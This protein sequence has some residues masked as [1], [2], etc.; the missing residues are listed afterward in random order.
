MRHVHVE[1]HGTFLGLR[2]KRLVVKR[3]EGEEREYALNRTRSLTVHGRAHSV[4]SALLLAL[5]ARG[6]RFSVI[7]G[8]GDSAMLVESSRHATAQVRSSQHHQLQE[9]VPCQA[10]CR[11]VIATKIANQRAVLLYFSKY[12]AKRHEPDSAAIRDA[13]GRLKV[14]VESVRR[15]RL[16]TNANWRD[17]LLGLEGQ[18]ASV[19]WGTLAE[20]IMLPGDFE[21][22]EG[23]GARDVANAG[24]NYGYAILA[25]R[26]QSAL[27]NA[28]LDLH[29]GFLHA[30]RPGKPALVLDLMEEYRAWTV[31]RSLIK[32]RRALSGCET[33]TQK[34][35]QRI[36]REVSD[37]FSR[38]YP[39][40]GR[41]L[42][43]DSIIQ[44]QCYRLAGSFCG[45]SAY[46]GYRFRW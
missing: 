36:A 25:S 45:G 27:L 5:S 10:W 33:L 34:A 2:G 20:Q 14:S 17:R 43:L 15:V 29:A 1:G 21:R 24:L 46:R 26:I 19:Y 11:E 32:L 18:A 44:R 4:S 13:A 28:G 16:P 39:W 42:S 30:M 7:S 41:R 12:A 22:R 6:I 3:G 9:N 37:T 31:D 40:R 23:R 8:G 35:R 38:R